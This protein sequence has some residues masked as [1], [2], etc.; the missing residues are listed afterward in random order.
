M[1]ASSTIALLAFC[2]TT[3]AIVFPG[4]APTAV[5]EA[6]LNGRSPRPT[7][8]PP[9]LP[10]LFRRQQRDNGMCGYLNGDSEAPVSCSIGTC[11][12]DDTIS[13]FG[14]C[15]G[16][17]RSDCELFTTCVGSAS[18][19]SC[20][21]NSACANDDFAL[22]CTA[23]TAGVCMTMW[24][25]VDEGS[26]SNYVCGSSSTRVQVVATP[27]AGAGS[28]SGTARSTSISGLSSSRDGDDDSTAAIQ[29]SRP[30]ASSTSSD[31]R[32]RINTAVTGTTRAAA[33]TSQ[34]TAA[35]MKTAQVVLGAVGGL[36]GVIAL[37][38]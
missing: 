6:N 10:E 28:V 7:G 22:A 32:P 11:L 36:A 16:S 27:T 26:V 3:F 2:Q 13:W 19:S 25:E 38:V 5:G 23:S 17:S 29:T 18:I 37:F 14:C 24:G 34:S 35:A 20:L 30:G 15:T 1:L 9:S 12:Y 4:P 21:S 31:D 8:G 33:T